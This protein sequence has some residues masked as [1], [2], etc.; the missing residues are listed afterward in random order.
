MTEGLPVSGDYA[1]QHFPACI[2]TPDMKRILTAV[3]LVPI[4]LLVIFISPRWPI[5]LMAV[6][7]VVAALALWEYLG[8][9]NAIGAKT[10]RVVVVVCLA[11]LMAAVFRDRKSVV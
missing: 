6:V 11:I 4:V 1:P 8:L 10:P 2:L 7:F 5:A 9:A 3:V